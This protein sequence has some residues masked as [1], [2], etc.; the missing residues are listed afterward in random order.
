MVRVGLGADIRRISALLAETTKAAPG[1]LSDRA[2]AVRLDDAN[3]ETVVLNIS[4][5]TDSRRT[6]F[7]D[8]TSQ[9]RQAA[10]D[11]LIAC[12]HTPPDA[13]LRRVELTNP[14]DWDK[15]GGTGT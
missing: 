13:A 8:T 4:F 1:V 12:G 3:D 10:V 2:V 6:D 15:L 9:V 7:K 14:G 5:W 11:V